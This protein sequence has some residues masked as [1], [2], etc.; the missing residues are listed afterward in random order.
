VRTVLGGNLMAYNHFAVPGTLGYL[1]NSFPVG[2]VR[3]FV[4]PE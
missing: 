4:P 3:F 2:A 1:G